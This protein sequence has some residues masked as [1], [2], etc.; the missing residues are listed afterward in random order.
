MLSRLRAGLEAEEVY[1]AFQMRV[2]SPGNVVPGP[3][4]AV[5]WARRGAAT[6]GL[7]ERAQNQ[8][9]RPG[10]NGRWWSSAWAAAT[11]AS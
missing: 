4:G 5:A 6:S 1:H 9:M 11:G 10:A 2:A 7:R 3:G 8:K